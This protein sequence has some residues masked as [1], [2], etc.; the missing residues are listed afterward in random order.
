[1]KNFLE[2]LATDLKLNVVVNGKAIDANLH[3]P[4]IFN[5]HDTVT[6]DDVEVLPRFHYLANNGT[7]TIS[8]PFYNWY[9]RISG[10]GWLL[11][12]HQG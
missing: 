9:H 3:D 10:H 4:L 12:P 7:L 5:A 6:V 1:M 8:E 2:L 11:T